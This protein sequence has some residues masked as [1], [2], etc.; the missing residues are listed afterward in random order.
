MQV[1]NVYVHFREEEQ[2][3]NALRGLNG[4]YYAGQDEEMEL[5]SSNIVF[6]LFFVVFKLFQLLLHDK[7]VQYFTMNTIP[8]GVR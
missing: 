5:V 3:A 4:R 8:Q 2:A 1:G 7:P 6:F